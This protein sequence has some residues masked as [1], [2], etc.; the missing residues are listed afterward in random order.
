MQVYDEIV[1][2]D[3]GKLRPS[4]TKRFKK[5]LDP[6]VRGFGYWIWKPEVVLDIL[7]QLNHGDTLHYADAGFHFN[8][9]GR[10]RLLDYFALAANHDSGILG[11]KAVPPNSEALVWDGRPLPDWTNKMW[12]KMD[13]LCELGL[14]NNASFLND[15][16]FEAGTFVVTRSDESI[17]FIQDW[18]ELMTT[19]MHL[20]DDSPS[21][22]P[23]DPTFVEH[24]H[25]QSVFSCLAYVHRIASVSSREHSY[26]GWNGGKDWSALRLCPLHQRRSIRRTLWLEQPWRVKVRSVGRRAGKI[27]ARPWR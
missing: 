21:S 5:L 27:V 1:V 22:T 20:I 14:A 19:K 12:T 3:E 16:T 10:T 9:R 25:D 2:L 17:R 7:G 13:L 18:H 15:S 6:S 8:R 24:R 4:F 26:P 23:N 11:F